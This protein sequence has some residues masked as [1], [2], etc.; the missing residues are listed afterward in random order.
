[1]RFTRRR[2]RRNIGQTRKRGVGRRQV[3]KRR[4]RKIR[5]GLFGFEKNKKVAPLDTANLEFDT[6]VFSKELTEEK[7]PW[8]SR[9]RDSLLRSRLESDWEANYARFGNK[10]VEELE[11][12]L[13]EIQKEKNEKGEKEEIENTL[14]YVMIALILDKIDRTTGVSSKDIVKNNREEINRRLSEF[15][16][17]GEQSYTDES[18][19]KLNTK[20]TLSEPQLESLKKNLGEILYYLRMKYSHGED[21]HDI[22][23][24]VQEP[25]KLSFQFIEY[26]LFII[27]NHL[28]KFGKKNK[29]SD[30]VFSTFDDYKTGKYKTNSE[31]ES[32]GSTNSTK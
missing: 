20:L 29:D 27:E 12:Y 14:K 22:L 28:F 17:K 11:N 16:Y 21:I 31:T 23:S 30:F 6:G 26:L 18:K 10:D 8:F 5:G 19:T 7:R 25:A 3:G 24:G 4:T 9:L 13:L 1:M 32:I 15:L 2:S